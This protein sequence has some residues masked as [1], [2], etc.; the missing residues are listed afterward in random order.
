[1][2]NIISRISLIQGQ[3][4]PFTPD[5]TGVS[6]RKTEMRRRDKAFIFF[7][8]EEETLHETPGKD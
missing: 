6:K 8:R 4:S 3:F 2:W 1:M 7:C 5:F